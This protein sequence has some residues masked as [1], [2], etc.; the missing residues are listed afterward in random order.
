MPAGLSIVVQPQAPYRAPQG[1]ICLDVGHLFS[2]FLYHMYVC[3]F[4]SKYM[5]H[6][7]DIHYVFVFQCVSQYALNRDTIHYVK[8]INCKIKLK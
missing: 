1:I 2:L 4:L 8:Y 5:L 6:W 3:I 7:S